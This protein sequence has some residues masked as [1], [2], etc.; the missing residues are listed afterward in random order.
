VNNPSISTSIG[1]FALSEYCLP[2]GERSWSFWRA[3]R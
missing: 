2:V 3:Q 1:D